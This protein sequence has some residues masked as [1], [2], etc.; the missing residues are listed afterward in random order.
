MKVATRSSRTGVRGHA[1]SRIF[2]EAGAGSKRKEHTTP[3]PSQQITSVLTLYLP[4]SSDNVRSIPQLP[5]QQSTV[6][7]SDTRMPRPTQHTKDGHSRHPEKMEERAG[8]GAGDDYP[9]SWRKEAKR[10]ARRSAERMSRASQGSTH[11]RPVY[12]NA[13]TDTHTHAGILQE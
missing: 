3:F 10:R 1:C 4:P 6:R 7:V 11:T 2:I 5:Q 12:M 8:V 9:R 13:H